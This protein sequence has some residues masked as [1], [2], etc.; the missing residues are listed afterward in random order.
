M[1]RDANLE[2]LNRST[3]AVHTSPPQNMQALVTY[4]RAHYPHIAP[5]I[6][7]STL[8]HLPQHLVD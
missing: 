1:L 3:T 5:L 4:Y 6:F 8:K 2:S 7:V